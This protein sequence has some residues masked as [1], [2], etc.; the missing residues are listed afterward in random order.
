MEKWTWV[1]VLHPIFFFFFW[2]DN[3]SPFQKIS[4][5]NWGLLTPRNKGNL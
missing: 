5:H 4:V 2:S 1:E 3:D